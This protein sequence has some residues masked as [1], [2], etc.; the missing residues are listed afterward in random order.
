MRLGLVLWFAAIPLAAHH[1]TRGTFDD[2]KLVATQG[3]ITEVQWMN[4][5]FRFFMDVTSD[6]GNV[7]SWKMRGLRQTCWGARA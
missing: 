1:S 4:P 3:V 5:H 2:S 7:A 6:A